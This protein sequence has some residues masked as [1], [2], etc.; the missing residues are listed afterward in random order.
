[1]NGKRRIHKLNGVPQKSLLLF[2]FIQIVLL[3]AAP[4]CCLS[5]FLKSAE[6]TLAFS[7]AFCCSSFSLLLFVTQISHVSYS[8]TLLK[9]CLCCSFLPL[10]FL[11]CFRFSSFLFASLC[12][13]LL[14]F[15][16][17]SLFLFSLLLLAAFYC[18][19]F[20]FVSSLFL[21]LFLSENEALKSEKHQIQ[22]LLRIPT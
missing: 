19:L 12:F 20:I 21:C 22:L 3:F 16:A 13:I 5:R 4:C 8:K 10:P 15:A 11:C 17:L 14:L 9:P 7:V 18:S 1:M 6:L 2:I